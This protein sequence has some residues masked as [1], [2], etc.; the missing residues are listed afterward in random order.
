MEGKRLKPLNDFAFRKVMGERGDEQQLLGFLNA[1]LARTGKGNLTGVKIREDKDLPADLAGGKAARLDVLG[2][3][4]NGSLINIEVQLKNEHNIAKRSLFYWS[5]GYIRDFRQGDDYQDLLPVIT[6]NILG[7]GYLALEEYHTSFHLWEDRRKD[8]MLTDV[9]ELHFIDMVKF[10]RFK[11]LGAGG[12]FN[13]NDPL[14]RWLTWLDDNSPKEQIEEVVKMDSAILMAQ[15]KLEV[16]ARTPELLRAYEGYEKAASD[17]T[18]S[19]NGARWE[20]KQA[21]LREGK[22]AGLREGEQKKAVEIARGLKAE[23]FPVDTIA[24]IAG[25]PR[26]VV[27]SL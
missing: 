17:W 15:T 11:A 10:R 23:G 7:F 27:E 16:I 20:G 6:I 18:S 14:H 13:L 1:V 4:E 19:I 22:Q 2:N 5:S 12:G 3:L 26:D 25:L 8:Y 24:R 21:G 9:C